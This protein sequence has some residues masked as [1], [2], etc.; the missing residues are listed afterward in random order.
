MRN[1][2][3]VTHSTQYP[4]LMIGVLSG[5]Y[6]SVANGLHPEAGVFITLNKKIAYY[7]VPIWRLIGYEMSEIFPFYMK[8]SGTTF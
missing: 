8:Y 1:T 3:L 5:G 4:K 2:W 7:H 6:I